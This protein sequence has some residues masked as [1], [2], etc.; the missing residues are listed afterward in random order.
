MMSYKTK[1]NRVS[2]FKRVDFT[3]GRTL[4]KGDIVTISDCIIKDKTLMY[5]VTDVDGHRYKV[6]YS[7]LDI[8]NGQY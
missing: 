1:Y 6:I 7:D 4:N 2:M 3:N 5:K 8:H